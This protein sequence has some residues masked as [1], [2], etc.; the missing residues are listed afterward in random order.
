MMLTASTGTALA[1]ASKGGPTQGGTPPAGCTQETYTKNGRTVTECIPNAALG[2]A[3]PAGLTA[4]DECAFEAAFKI[5]VV[6]KVLEKFFG[7]GVLAADASAGASVKDLF[8]SV[9]DPRPFPD[10][11]RV[12]VSGH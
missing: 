12:I 3:V 9:I 5:P 7:L 2:L 8:L 6:G 11:T 10:C 4:G 1:A